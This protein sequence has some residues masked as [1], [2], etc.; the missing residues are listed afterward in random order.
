MVKTMTDKTI[1][2]FSAALI[3]VA[4]LSCTPEELAPHKVKTTYSDKISVV[5]PGGNAFVSGDQVAAFK[6]DGTK[7]IYSTAGDNDFS[8]EDDVEIPSRIAYVVFPPS[9]KD[10]L[11]KGQFIETLSSFQKATE[12]GY[13]RSSAFCAGHLIDNEAQLQHT[14]SFLSFKLVQDEVASVRLTCPDGKIAGEYSFAMKEIV[15]SGK[16]DKSTNEITLTGDF[17]RGKSYS[18]AIIPGTFTSFDIQMRNSSGSLVWSKNVAIDKTTLNTGESLDLGEFGN[19]MAAALTI[20]ASS[21]ELSGYTLRSISGYRESDGSQVIGGEYE[22]VMT[23][24][25]VSFKVYGLEPA[26][27]SEE[28]IWLL[29]NLVKDGTEVTIPMK[30]ENL[31]LKPS[32][33][34]L[35]EIRPLSLSG[36]D[37]P[38]FYPYRDARQVC[39]AGYAYGE[40]NTYL[41]QSKSS[42]YSG[43]VFSPDDNI[44]SEVTIDFRGRGDFVKVKPFDLEEISFSFLTYGDNGRVYTQ[45]V[46]SRYTSI[47]NSSSYEIDLSRKSEYKVILRNTGAHA[48]SPI[49]L[50]KSGDTVLWAWTFWNV[51]A[52]GT[53]LETVKAGGVEIANLD[54][55]QATN[56]Y[57]KFVAAKGTDPNRSHPVRRTA[58]YYQWG[59]PLPSFWQDAVGIWLSPANPNNHSSTP[60]MYV[61][62]VGAVTMEEMLSF[63]GAYI[64]NNYTKGIKN[65]SS[66]FRDWCGGNAADESGLWGG[67]DELTG[68]GVK[69]LYDPCPQGWRV[70]DYKTFYS[71]FGEYRTSELVTPLKTI[72][73]ATVREP[74]MAMGYEGFNMETVIDKSSSEESTGGGHHI[75]TCGSLNPGISA[76]AGLGNTAVLAS[77][78]SNS[79]GEWSNS[80]NNNSGDIWTNQMSAGS[81]YT[82]GM[83]TSNGKIGMQSRTVSSGCNVRCQKDDTDR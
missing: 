24:N 44:P 65:D 42:T 40:A 21:E 75:L 9:P 11:H 74:D 2:I 6:L 16:T 46:D 3:S 61:A 52:D 15:T 70:A 66:A 49:L 25:P 64:T 76:T 19:A 29:F 53:R 51:A 8:L 79:G 83:N 27:Y 31:N 78:W 32:Q 1:K 14:V 81:G 38:W 37:A 28:T 13:D 41:I 47:T 73:S 55:G 59:R 69:S 50:M 54:L 39:G 35:A 7:Y 68:K 45:S 72:S 82:L 22:T 4:V 34:T 71:V 17:Q 62:S 20:I 43:A 58:F 10:S 63:A 5:L 18:F 23:G 12:G 77:S 30:L 48:G 26:D 57:S 56:Q 80:V 67:A 33:N 36:N 60:Q